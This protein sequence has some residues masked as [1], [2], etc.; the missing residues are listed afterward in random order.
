MLAW[1]AEGIDLGGK[2]DL[3]AYVMVLNPEARDYAFQ[4][5]TTLRAD[6]FRSEMD[7]MQKS[8]KGQFKAADRAKAK[9]T[10]LIGEDEMQNK[11]VTIKNK[12][13][14]TQESISLEELVPFLDEA[15]DQEVHD[16]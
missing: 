2:H 5:L 6:G 7:F 9:V 12:V 11:T 3:D 8:F 16:H 13:A 15:F 10:L 14:K 1:E 4:V